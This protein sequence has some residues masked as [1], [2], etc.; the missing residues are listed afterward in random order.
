[1]AEAL[2]AIGVVASLVQLID[3]TKKMINVTNELC[4]KSSR[5]LTTVKAI[6]TECTTLQSALTS[7][8]SWV[9]SQA[10]SSAQLDSLRQTISVLSEAMEALL[11]DLSRVNDSLRARLSFLWN[12]ES[13]RLLLEEVRWQ[14]NALHLLLAA[15]QL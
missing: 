3:V 14:A 10:H 13:L 5:M 9:E 8:N 15:L 11:A 6:G 1:M 7:I 4:E 12:D 2:A